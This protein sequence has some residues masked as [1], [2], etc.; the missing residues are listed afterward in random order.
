MLG[1]EGLQPAAG[2]EGFETWDCTG[3][4]LENQEAKAAFV[5]I[6]VGG[7]ISVNKACYRMWGEPKACQVMFDPQRRRIGLKPVSPDVENSYDL[8][9][10]QVQIPCKKLFDYYGVTIARLMRYHD[11]KVVDG[12]LVIDL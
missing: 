12:V 7:V 9:G 3:Y 4:A 2:L 10:Q 8:S 6:R 1:I 11:P 5:S